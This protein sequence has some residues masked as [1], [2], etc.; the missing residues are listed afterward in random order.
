MPTDHPNEDMVI[1]AGVVAPE[2]TLS[3]SDGNALT[4]SQ[5]LLAGPLVLVFYRGDW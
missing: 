2:F 3:G 1:K 4:L 5:G